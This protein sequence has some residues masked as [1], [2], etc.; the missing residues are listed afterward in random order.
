MRRQ[1]TRL[2]DKFSEDKANLK[3]EII[4]NSSRRASNAFGSN[5]KLFTSNKREYGLRDSIYEE[6]ILITDSPL[7]NSKPLILM[8]NIPSYLESPDQSLDRGF[9]NTLDEVMEDDSEDVLE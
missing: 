8:I 4:T 1:T 5:S 2:S 9:T 6:Q 7:Y 3:I